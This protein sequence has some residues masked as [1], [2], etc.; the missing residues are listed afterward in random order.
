[1]GNFQ[2]K[3]DELGG[4]AKEAAGNAVGNDD[5]ANEGKGD[6]VKADAKQAV[7]DAKDKVTEGLGKLKGDE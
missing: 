1:M 5:L 7:E 4:K 6:Q 2:N 3:A